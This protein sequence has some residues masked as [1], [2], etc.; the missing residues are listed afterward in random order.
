LG[1]YSSLSQ[2]FQHMLEE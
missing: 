2:K 1:F